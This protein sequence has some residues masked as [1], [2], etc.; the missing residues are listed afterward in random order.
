ML[1]PRLYPTFFLSEIGLTNLFWCMKPHS[2]PI[3]G[4]LQKSV[5][6]ML[7]D[8]SSLMEWTFKCYTCAGTSYEVALSFGYDGL[9]SKY[10]WLQISVQHSI[11]LSLVDISIKI[12]SIARRLLRIRWEI[13]IQINC[14]DSA[15]GQPHGDPQHLAISPSNLLMCL[16]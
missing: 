4:I 2:Y 10:N 11:L 9:E 5:I 14:N 13:S 16:Q 15:F 6:S 7:Q 3:C 1:S 8:Y 12:F